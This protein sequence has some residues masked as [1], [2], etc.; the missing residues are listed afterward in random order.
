M[1]ISGAASRKT[2]ARLLRCF[3]FFVVPKQLLKKWTE[4]EIFCFQSSILI[5]YIVEY[6][7]LIYAF[8]KT[9]IDLVFQQPTLQP[10]TVG[11]TQTFCYR[12]TKFSE[13]TRSAHCYKSGKVHLWEEESCTSILLARYIN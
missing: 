9:R 8:L 12:N 6:L 1:V 10:N 4:Q 11:P 3:S 5:K 2:E 7:E 13:L